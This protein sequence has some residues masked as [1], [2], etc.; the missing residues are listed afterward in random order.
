MVRQGQE[1]VLIFSGR[2]RVVM[3]CCCLQSAICVCV[4][5]V[6]EG[7]GLYNDA[8]SGYNFACY[9]CAFGDLYGSEH[10]KRSVVHARCNHR[11][12]LCLCMDFVP[13]RRRQLSKT[14][15]V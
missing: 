2:R 7:S 14:G 4:C 8:H 5:R 11:S 6:A 13:L 12:V 9:V 15:C 3:L 1:A 10:R